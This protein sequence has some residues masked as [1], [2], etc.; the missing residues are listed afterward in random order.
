[1]VDEESHRPRCQK[2]EERPCDHR[3]QADE[4]PT[5][6]RTEVVRSIEGLNQSPFPQP[7]M[8][9][10]APEWIRQAPERIP[11]Q[12]EGGE[13]GQKGEGSLEQK[14]EHGLPPR[15]VPKGRLHPSEGTGTGRERL[16]V[17]DN[18]VDECAGQN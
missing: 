17:F 12:T 15:P 2:E 7:A 9:G 10:D 14:I 5:I 8:I 11:P 16:R 3:G 1:E 4:S 18:V 13:D 6:S